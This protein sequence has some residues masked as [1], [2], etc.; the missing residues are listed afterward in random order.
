M[1]AETIEHEPRR[2][3]FSIRALEARDLPGLE[4]EGEYTHFRR[5]YARAYERAQAGNAALWLLEDEDAR[6]VGQVF[7]LLRN[8]YDPQLA[9]GVQLAFIH[10]FRVRPECR[11]A[12]LGTQLMHH[13]E[14]DL[15]RRG[16][17]QVALN[18]ARD[19]EG[20]LRLYQRLGYRTL[21]PISG[22]WS[23]IDHLGQERQLHEPGWRLAKDL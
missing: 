4:W 11:N 2:G 23:F 5:V 14:A 13:A 12:G 9:D 1:S 21:H 18:V 8:E 7:V 16:F 20:A 19:N 22:Y 6:L 10:S 15:R 3:S 17:R